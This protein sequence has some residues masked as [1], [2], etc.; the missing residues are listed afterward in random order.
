MRLAIV[1]RESSVRAGG[2]ALESQHCQPPGEGKVAL[3]VNELAAFVLHFDLC[4]GEDGCWVWGL[5]V[6]MSSAVNGG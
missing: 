4:V 1:L 2:A 3:T 5:V 6:S